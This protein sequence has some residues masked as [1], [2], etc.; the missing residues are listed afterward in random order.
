MKKFS[1]LIP[2]VAL[3]TLLVT[4][5]VITKSEQNVETQKEGDLLPI[6]L[7]HHSHYVAWVDD[8]PSNGYVT[9]NHNLGGNPE[10]YL[11]FVTGKNDHGRTHMHFGLAE[12]RDGLGSAWYGVEWLELNS[13]TITLYKSENDESLPN[14]KQWIRARVIIIRV[15]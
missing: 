10:H 7:P 11:V 4:F 12:Q 8:W 14:R 3:A 6:C 15:I 1:M 13:S 9:L 5:A 2:V